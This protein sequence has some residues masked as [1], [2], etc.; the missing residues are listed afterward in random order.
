MGI[1]LGWGGIRLDEAKLAVTTLHNASTGQD[2]FVLDDPM[3]YTC[4][5]TSSERERWERGWGNS[6]GL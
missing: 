2:K 5:R 3:K 4:V 6:Y 1:G